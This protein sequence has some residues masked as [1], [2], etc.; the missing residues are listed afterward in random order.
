MELKRTLDRYAI[1]KG[2]N[3]KIKRSDKRLMKVVCQDGCPFLLYA[4]RD[5]MNVGFQV[6]TLCYEHRCARV[7]KNPRASVRW[8]ANHFKEKVQE[9]PQ[10]KVSKMKKEVE[11]DLKVN[12]SLHK[13]KRAK[14]MIMQEM[15]G[16]FTDE[17][18]RLEAYCNEVRSSNPGS[19]VSVE[20][21]REALE[22]GRRV[23][24]RMYLCFNASK[25]GWRTGCRPLIGVDDTF[26]KGKAKGILLIAVS[27]DVNDSLY[28]L[29]FGL[30]SR[31]WALLD[32]VPSMATKV[33]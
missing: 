25:V 19:D 33:I 15:E 16:S 4:S 3:L 32:L 6:K 2:V 27:L 14:R 10:F 30:V 7:Y 13:C 26:L 28:L 12:V 22:Q 24:K 11:L 1:R 20:L 31:K 8:L 18:G 23:F 9:M 29:A 21:S 17:F 5:R